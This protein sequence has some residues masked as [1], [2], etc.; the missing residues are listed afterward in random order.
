MSGFRRLLN[1]AADLFLAHTRI[2]M[3]IVL[4]IC[5]VITVIIAINARDRA[6]AERASEAVM[7]EDIIEEHEL[8][9][10]IMIPELPLDLN[11]HPEV[12]A[13]M[14]EYYQ[15]KVDGDSVRAAELC[16]DLGEIDMIKLEELS[17]YVERHDKIDV[18]TK[19]GLTP[20][21]YVVYVVRWA[22][23]YDIDA[24]TPGVQMYYVMPDEDG[25]LII[26]IDESKLDEKIMDYIKAVSLQDNVIDLYNKVAVEFN[27]MIAADRE[28]E[29]FLAFMTAKAVEN[30]GIV[31]AQMI[32]SDEIDNQIQDEPDDNDNINDDDVQVSD[33]TVLARTNAVV[34]IRSSDSETAERVGRAIVG[35]EF[36]VLEQRGNG[37][38]RIRYNNR[39]AYIKSEFLDVVGEVGG[40]VESA[41]AYATAGR[42]RVTGTN[43]RVRSTAS[44]SGD[45]LGTVSRGDRFDYIET[46]SG[47]AKIKYNN[48]VGYIR[49]DF[50]DVERN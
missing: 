9:D 34:N 13:L 35:Q 7:D 12:N 48:Q 29:E 6:D 49:N 19:D 39:D 28:L 25:N 21:S 40:Q 42:V 27:D 26:R 8:P 43:V 30:V 23:F 24:V 10:S 11:K 31:L 18:Y 45:V 44:T 1:T 14:M 36:T 37:W 5:V 4:V 16:I 38:S 46:V 50:I 3:P 32:Q 2:I 17:K 33:V 47:W 15:A 41:S 20:G 22:K